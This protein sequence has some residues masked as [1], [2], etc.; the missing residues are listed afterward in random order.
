MQGES[1]TVDL[2]INARPCMHKKLHVIQNRSLFLPQPQ[3]KSISVRILWNTIVDCFHISRI[4]TLNI[5][6]LPDKLKRCC[7]ESWI[8][9]HMGN[10][11]HIVVC[12]LL[13][14]AENLCERSFVDRKWETNRYYIIQKPMF[15]ITEWSF[16]LILSVIEKQSA[17]SMDAG[18][19]GEVYCTMLDTVFLPSF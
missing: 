14:R 9:C 11:T 10:S 8:T 4:I 6:F 13:L 5:N 18:A 15:N 16:L 12:W 19:D 3:P 7:L 2:P 17:I 1:D